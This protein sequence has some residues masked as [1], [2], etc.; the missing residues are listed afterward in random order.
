MS[1]NPDD[2]LSEQNTLEYD[3]KAITRGKVKNKLARYD[4]CF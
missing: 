4:I 3:K 1:I 2:L